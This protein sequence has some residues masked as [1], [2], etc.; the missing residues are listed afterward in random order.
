VGITDVADLAERDRGSEPNGADPGESMNDESHV[1]AGPLDRPAVVSVALRLPGAD[2]LS[3]DRGTP[4]DRGTPSEPDTNLFDHERFG[5]TAEEAQRTDTRT[6]LLLE[7]VDEALHAA[8]VP[9]AQHDTTAVFTE[10]PTSARQLADRLGLDG[11][12]GTVRVDG[13]HAVHLGCRALLAREADVVVAAVGDTTGVA[14]VVLKRLDDATTAGDDVL[15]VVGDSTTDTGDLVSVVDA[16][17]TLRADTVDAGGLVLAPAPTLPAGPA[18]DH[19]V[20]LLDSHH[21]DTLDAD[22]A[23]LRS[24]LE[25]EP[26]A[27][28]DLAARSQRRAHRH[29][30]RRYVSIDGSADLDQRF[31][32]ANLRRATRRPPTRPAPVAFAFPGVGSEYV[33]M[34]A[35]LARESEVFR[36]SLARTSALAAQAGHPIDHL[37]TPPEQAATAPAAGIDLKS[38]VLRARNGPSGTRFDGLPQV[39]L[40][41]FAVQLAFVDLL[42]SAGVRP[43]AVLGHSLGEW[44]AATVAGAVRREDAVGFVAARAALVEQV[45][46]GATIAVADHADAVGPLLAGTGMAL[47]ADNGPQD[48]TVSGLA[49]H[50]PALAAVLDRADMV[51]QRLDADTAFHSPHLGGAADALAERLRG[52]RFADPAIP[53]AS[54]VTGTWLSGARPDADY[55]RT[56][57]TSPV[58]FRQALTTVSA[59]FPVLVEIGP[60]AIRPWAS[61]TTRG[62]DAVRT[63]RNSYERVPELDVVERTL[64]QLWL[65]G[66]EPNWPKDPAARPRLPLPIPPPAL[67]RR[68]RQ[69]SRTED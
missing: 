7:V 1:T 68:T 34:G 16:I 60:G 30:H 11:P 37:F 42:A 64:A 35:E 54:G 55:W 45:P 52:A 3:S 47:A 36:A 44:T 53:M 18:T 29:G 62:T 14:A 56:Q 22:T 38:I 41:L 51:Y 10:G 23:A 9:A 66:H 43:D 26:G 33:G 12:T 50:A 63:A 67:L 69:P 59:K 21:P 46:G 48:C 2:S 32:P 19:G 15:A 28:A 49:D 61:Q 6:R 17:P 25:A 4:P 57:L 20:V 31:S 58:L 8:A 40:S 5:M 39:H 27:V 24:L 65:H 13:P